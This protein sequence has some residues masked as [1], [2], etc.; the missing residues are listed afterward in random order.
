[1]A[2]GGQC[3]CQVVK[4]SGGAQANGG[5]LV[6]MVGWWSFGEFKGYDFF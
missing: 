1:M 6:E 2:V 4:I 3:C 5:E